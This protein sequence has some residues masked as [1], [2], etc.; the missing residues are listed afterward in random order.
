MVRGVE[1]LGAWA[2]GSLLAA[3]K[4]K[5]TVEIDKDSFLQYGLAC[6]KRDIE[7]QQQPAASAGLSQQQRQSHHGPPIPRVGVGEKP[8]WTLGGWA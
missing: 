1:T 7:Q 8:V 5:G 6:A 2:G 4:V 3:L